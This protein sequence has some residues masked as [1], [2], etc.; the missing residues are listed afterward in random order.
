VIFYSNKKYP[1]HLYRVLSCG[2]RFSNPV[3]I[4]QISLQ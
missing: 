4:R 1:P 2:K 3:E